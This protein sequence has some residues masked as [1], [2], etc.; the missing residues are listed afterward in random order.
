MVATETRSIFQSLTGLFADRKIGVKIA[1]GFL[2]VLAITATISAISYFAFGTVATSFQTY[3]QRVQVVGIVRDVDRE[4]L[5]FRRFVREYALT[6]DEASI[7]LAQDTRKT[8]GDAIASGI[9][10]IKNPERNAKMKE[11]S[12]QFQIYSKDF[13]ML[14]PLHREEIKLT[15][16]V[17]DPSGL[18]LRVDFEKLQQWTS[19]KAGNSN[20]MILA[21]EGLKQV[22]MARL[23]VNKLL[24]RHDMAAAEAAEKAFVDLKTVLAGLDGVVG[25][26]EGGSLLGEIK[27]LVDKYHQAYR[28]A[29]E[30]SEQIDHLVNGQM[31]DKANALAKD[32]DA[33]KQNGVAEEQVIEHA[34]SELINSREQFILLL[35]F[36]GLLLGSLLA[37]VIGRAISKPLVGLVL[38][39]QKLGEGQFDVVL[40]GLGRADEVGAMAGAVESFKVKLAEKAREEAEEKAQADLRAAEAKRAADDREAAQ[41]RAADEKAAVDRK[42][43]MHKLADEFEKAVGNIVDN[44]SSASTELEAAANTLTKTAET[45]Q[46]LSTVVASA[47]EEASANVQSV[48]SATEEMTGSVGEISRQV[49]ESSNIAK[50]AVMQAQQT[51]ARITE[52]SHAA[53]R[54][55]DVVKLI[56]AVAEQTNLLALNA[57][58]EA[59]RAGEAGRGFAVVASEVKALAAQTAKA[60]GEISSQIGSMQTA[61]QVSVAAIK[62]IGG[63]IGHIS[64]IAATIAAAVEEQGAATQEISRN[65]QEAAKGT[66]QVATNIVS[67]NR[68][69]GE[70]GSASSQVL[71]SAQ[72]L[73]SESSH[74][75]VEVQKFLATVRAA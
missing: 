25:A 29:A 30:L 62:E 26:G 44:V 5:S 48:A 73:S 39:V 18:K 7:K 22:M 53:N 20:A 49:Q 16:E 56:T 63:T 15:N 61:T 59:A 72:S 74:L 58:I 42:T 14:V 4:F 47:S 17:L 52:L 27:M 71:A 36:C 50:Q 13:D 60:T 37:W 12:D 70:T 35:A 6:G 68:G 46:E 75:K 65:V 10:E 51:D 64:E 2:C 31:V 3:G 23:N 19:A 32:A 9:R 40:P 45:T 1:I 34:T 24:G 69:A 38:G 67:V 8:V 28:R 54:I 41:Q 21:G 33:I 55:G 66:A 43:A 11:L 57:T